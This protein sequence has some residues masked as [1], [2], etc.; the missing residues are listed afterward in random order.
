[1]TE[2]ERTAEINKRSAQITEDHLKKDGAASL[3]TFKEAAAKKE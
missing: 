1:M 2:I 3:K